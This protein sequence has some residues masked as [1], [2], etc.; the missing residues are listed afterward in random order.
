MKRKLRTL[1]EKEIYLDGGFGR[2]GFIY[3][4]SD[5]EQAVE[6]AFNKIMNLYIEDRMSAQNIVEAFKDKFGSKLQVLTK[7]INR[8]CVIN[9]DGVVGRMNWNKINIR[10]ILSSL[11][12]LEEETLMI[13]ATS[14]IIYSD[15]KEE[16]S[17]S[18]R[19][20]AE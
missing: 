1:K 2:S 6:E 17:I 7:K 16:L 13:G 12:F 18:Y 5:V 10:S 9:V 4:S 20:I 8:K 19:R 15:G 3:N 14:T 11:R